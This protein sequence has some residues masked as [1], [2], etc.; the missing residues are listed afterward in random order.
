METITIHSTMAERANAALRPSDE[1]PPFPETSWTG[2]V[3][4]GLGLEDLFRAFNRVTQADVDYLLSID[5][6]LPSLSVGDTVERA[7]GTTHE[8]APVG[9]REV[10]R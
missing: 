7:D 2:E 6:R 5:Y 1:P 8:V 9:F 4:D 3:P 10:V